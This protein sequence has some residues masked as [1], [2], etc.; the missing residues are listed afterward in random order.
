M[1]P[2]RPRTDAVDERRP[3]RADAPE[4]FREAFDIAWQFSR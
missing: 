3:A 1:S 4:T 2:D